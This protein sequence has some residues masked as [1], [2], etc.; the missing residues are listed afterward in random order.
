[1][2]TEL[3]I[4]NFAIIDHLELNFQ[5]G[6]VTFTGETGAGKSIIIDA[7]EMVVGG[8]ADTSMIRSGADRAIVEATFTIPAESSASILEILER[9]ELVDQPEVVTLGREIRRSGRNVARVNGRSVST[10]LLS[11]IGDYLI[12]VHGQSE[13]LSLLRVREHVRLLDRFAGVD[14]PLAAYEKTYHKLHGVRGE[15]DELHQ[16][17]R[18]AAR[19]ADMLTYQINEIETARLLPG[20]EEDLKE[21]RNR[22][23]NAEGLASV[24]Q[25]ALQALE[26]GTPEA[27][28]ASDLIGQAV[29][30]VAA[31]VR[32]DPSQSELD[33]LAETITDSLSDLTR[34]LRIYQE[35][36]EFNPK[37]LDQVEDRLSLVQNLKRKYGN[38]IESILEFSQEAQRQL[39]AITHAGERIQE[40]TEEEKKLLALLAEQGVEL[41][42]RRKEA[43]EQLARSI[44][45]ELN[46]LHMSGARFQ[47]DFSQHPDPGGVP[48]P[49]GQKVAFYPN[50]LEQVE[51]LVAPN[52]GEG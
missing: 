49:D 36:I 12:D 14:E 35:N 9:E 13:H 47:V 8:R 34:S 3:H 7:V 29:H 15:L 1:M 10:S 33:E 2:L 48:L 44:E 22:L 5:P 6:L 18:D 16:A 20:E 43:A 52:P 50:G 4:E 21:E 51:F 19:R 39:D 38:S 27:P 28:A 24:T 45:A 42:S 41:S 11:E 32:L 25:E 30:A 46:D 40:L 17:E 26:E 23:A 37:R 31:L